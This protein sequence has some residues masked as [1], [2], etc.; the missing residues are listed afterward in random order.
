MSY[1][2]INESNFNKKEYYK[3]AKE[4][5]GNIVFEKF[6]KNFHDTFKIAYFN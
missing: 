5:G 1:N 6:S 2:G 3:L 4:L